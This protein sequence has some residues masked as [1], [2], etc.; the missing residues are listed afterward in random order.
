MTAAPGLP[1]E[2]KPVQ[3][4]IEVHRLQER[5]LIL[6]PNSKAKI[7]I[8]IIVKCNGLPKSVCQSMAPL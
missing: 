7:T 6:G 3:P 8:T 5:L 2:A 1:L 4:T